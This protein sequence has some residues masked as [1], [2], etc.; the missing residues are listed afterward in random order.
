MIFMI[1]TNPKED[2]CVVK[3]FQQFETNNFF[4]EFLHDIQVSYPEDNFAKSFDWPGVFAHF[5]P[6][7]PQ[8][9]INLHWLAQQINPPPHQPDRNEQEQTSTPNDENNMH[10]LIER[11]RC[12][13]PIATQQF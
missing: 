10:A 11:C 9:S 3:S 13:I 2:H 6:S 8:G 7:S 1:R 4:I 5:Q 12:R